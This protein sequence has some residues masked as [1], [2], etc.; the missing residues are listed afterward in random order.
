MHVCMHASTVLDET[1]W[2]K[3]QYD[4]LNTVPIVKYPLTLF[5]SETSWVMQSFKLLILWAE[6]WSVT[7][8]WKAVE[9]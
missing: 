1:C 5:Q 8:H 4:S 6:P 2:D 9:Q 3:L 7:I